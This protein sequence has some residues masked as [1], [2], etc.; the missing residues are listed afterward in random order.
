MF[1]NKQQFLQNN[2]SFYYGNFENQ[3]CMASS[4]VG[5]TAMLTLFIDSSECWKRQGRGR[6]K[7]AQDRGEKSVRVLGDI[8][9]RYSQEVCGQ[10][11]YQRRDPDFFHLVQN[12]QRDIITVAIA[13]VVIIVMIMRRKRGKRE[14]RRNTT[15]KC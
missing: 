11:W 1:L 6:R 3:R 8:Q 5:P 14:R 4:F 15:R 10:W 12:C 13:A 7:E 2:L 9:P